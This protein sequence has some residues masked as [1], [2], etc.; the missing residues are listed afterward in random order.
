MLTSVVIPIGVPTR[1]ILE[2]TACVLLVARQIVE[3]QIRMIAL[4]ILIVDVLVERKMHV[5]QAVTV[6]IF[7]HADHGAALG[8][9]AV[10]FC[11]DDALGAPYAR[12]PDPIVARA[13]LFETAPVLVRVE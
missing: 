11:E 12:P 9:E 3:P 7:A 8:L 4:A 2:I 10:G 13:D 5:R 6:A 1:L